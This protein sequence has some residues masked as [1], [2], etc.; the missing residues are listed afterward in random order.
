MRSNPGKLAALAA[1]LALGA[2]A[3]AHAFGA[4][5][6]P[7]SFPAAG[8]LTVGTLVA[9]AAPSAAARKVLVLR[10]F[11][12]DFRR[13]VVLAVRSRVGKDGKPW[14]Q[15]NLPMRPNGT[16]GWV[17]ASAIDV[18]PTKTRILINRDARKLSLYAGSKLM[19]RTTVAVGRP[20][21]ETPVG[22]FYVT[23]RFVPDNSFLGVFAFETS[24]YSRLTDWPGGGVVGIHGTSLP[25]LLGQ[26][27]SHGC[28]RMSNAAASFLRRY[29]PVG[30]PI[31][32][33]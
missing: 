15:L 32:I 29:V 8:E 7:A 11:R 23:S 30:T 19:Y 14:M 13:Q 18:H 25:Q 21:M 17:P 6:M 28:V 16:L 33:V 2:I 24:A 1:V 10:Q 20:G 27:V 31:K 4:S 9:R 3:P 26:A 22:S 12:K 5:T